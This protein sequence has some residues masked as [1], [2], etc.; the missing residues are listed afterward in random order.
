LKIGAE[1]ES[2]KAKLFFHDASK[3]S[4]AS[5]LNNEVANEVG[6]SSTSTKS[7]IHSTTNDVTRFFHNPT[8]KNH[9]LVHFKCFF[10]F[11][12]FLSRIMK[13]SCYV[14]PAGSGADLDT[15]SG[16]KNAVSSLSLA[17]QDCPYDLYPER[18]VSISTTEKNTPSPSTSITSK[19]TTPISPQELNHAFY[20]YDDTDDLLSLNTIFL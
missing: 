6:S 17:D 3:Y 13:K 4:F 11:F 1:V 5:L 2:S 15:S 19:K 16:E 14:V 20:Q 7:T 12:E 8:Q 9:F 18:V 10:D